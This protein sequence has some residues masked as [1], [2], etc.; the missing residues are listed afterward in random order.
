[1][2]PLP[3]TYTETR[4]ALHA[5]AEH[6]ISPV[7]YAA[8]GRIGLAVTPGGFGTPDLRARVENGTLIVDETLPSRSVVGVYT[9]TTDPGDA[10]MTRVDAVAAGALADWFAYCDA[11]LRELDP[12][13]EI[14]LWPEHFDIAC[15]VGECNYGGSPGD[16]HHPEPYLYV[17]PWGEHDDDPFWNEPFG[18]SL[19][20]AA[21]LGG[22]DGLGF[23]RRG[24]ATLR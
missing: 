1:M 8:E 21:I 3:P 24:R 17:G 13:A 23:L 4:R 19:P 12:N 22:A 15:V 18:A 14:T 16:E 10:D 20:Y 2:D 7:R 5:V 9:P 6:V 11:L